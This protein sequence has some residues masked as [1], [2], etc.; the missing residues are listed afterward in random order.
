MEPSND[1]NESGNE[2][3][4]PVPRTPEQSR[5]DLIRK[6]MALVRRKPQSGRPSQATFVPN[7]ECLEGR[8]MF[9]VSNLFFNGSTLELSGGSMIVA[10]DGHVWVAGDLI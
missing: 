1:R 10:A 7:A 2:S 4:E 9:S 5:R 3:H 8:T 6:L